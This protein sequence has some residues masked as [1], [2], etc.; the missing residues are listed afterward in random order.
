MAGVVRELRGIG[1]ICGFDHT[2][3]FSQRRSRTHSFICRQ[4]DETLSN[5]C[6]HFGFRRALVAAFAIPASP[7]PIALRAQSCFPT[8]N[9][10][11][12]VDTPFPAG[13]PLLNVVVL[14]ASLTWRD[15]LKRKGS[16]S[17][18]ATSQIEML[19]T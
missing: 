11:A 3:S 15:G 14:G 2:R 7:G 19:A 8:D 6:R 17:G 9:Y 5:N 4:I 1:R 10:V 12:V 16:N 18:K 13:S